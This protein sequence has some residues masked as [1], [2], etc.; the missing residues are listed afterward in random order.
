MSVPDGVRPEGGAPTDA[1]RAAWQALERC[2]HQIEEGEVPFQTRMGRDGLFAVRG[3]VFQER[4]KRAFR[5]AVVQEGCYMGEGTPTIAI[6]TVHGHPV[7]DNDWPP[8]TYVMSNAQVEE[9]DGEP[10][11]VP[12]KRN[13]RA[14][15]ISR[16]M[17]RTQFTPAETQQGADGLAAQRGLTT[18]VHQERSDLGIPGEEHRRRT[19]LAVAG[20]SMSTLLNQSPALAGEIPHVGCAVCG[21]LLA[22]PEEDKTDTDGS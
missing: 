11:T 7:H 13:A 2:F 20:I 6:Y 8:F 10:V 19:G 12:D 1:E 18:F 21:H 14:R 5:I 3:G 17:R 15:H 9:A 22:P 16:I 4:K